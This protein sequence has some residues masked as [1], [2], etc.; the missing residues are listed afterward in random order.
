MIIQ[1][2]LSTH[3][4]LALGSCNG[5]MCEKQSA[6]SNS[7]QATLSRQIQ[8]GVFARDKLCVCQ[9]ANFVCPLANCVSIEWRRKCG[10]SLLTR[11]A[12]IDLSVVICWLLLLI[13]LFRRE[14]AIHESRYPRD[15]FADR[16]STSLREKVHIRQRSS[17]TSSPTIH[18]SRNIHFFSGQLMLCPSSCPSGELSIWRAVH[19][20]SEISINCNSLLLANNSQWNTEIMY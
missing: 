11:R 10:E 3:T 16:I 12:V 9:L 8:L 19:L 18:R 4:C 15:S 1:G 13:C 5:Q 17:L 6:W 20:A 2:D 7:R 14:T